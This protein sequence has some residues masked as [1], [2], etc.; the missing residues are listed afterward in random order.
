MKWSQDSERQE[1]A[2]PLGRGQPE[3]CSRLGRHVCRLL[4]VSIGQELSELLRQERRL[5]VAQAQL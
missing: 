3:A 1:K 4:G 2:S 5:R